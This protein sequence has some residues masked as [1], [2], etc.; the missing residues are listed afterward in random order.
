MI[1]RLRR[2]AVWTTLPLLLALAGSGAVAQEPA[3]PPNEEPPTVAEPAAIPAAE[4]PTQA[5][6]TADVVLA[7]HSLAE[8][9][10]GVVSIAEALPEEEA[11]LARL[12]REA[13][14]Q[15]EGSPSIQRLKDSE[16]QWG[17]R[18]S[19][20]DEWLAT[21]SQRAADLETHL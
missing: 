20:L 8:P 14:Q 11:L 4:I 6:E 17:R 10:D 7:A 12:H 21:I 9:H 13:E 15:L 19:R 18:M 2:L 3:S 5:G 16:T 1:D